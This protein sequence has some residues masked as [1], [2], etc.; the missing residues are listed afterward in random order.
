M[1]EVVSIFL[2]GIT[3]VFLGM[4]LLYLSIRFTALAVGRFV[5]EAGKDG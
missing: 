1:S 3:S 5:G 2:G 4:T